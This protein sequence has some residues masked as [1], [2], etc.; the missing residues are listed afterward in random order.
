MRSQVLVSTRL[1]VLTV[2][3]AALVVAAPMASAQDDDLACGG[4]IDAVPIDGDS[5]FCDVNIGYLGLRRGGIGVYGLELNKD[6][7]T[8]YPF[9]CGLNSGSVAWGAV[10]S[11][12]VTW[13]NTTGEVIDS[14][15]GRQA[16]QAWYHEDGAWASVGWVDRW[17]SDPWQPDEERTWF[18]ATS[19]VYDMEPGVYTDRFRIVIDNKVWDEFS[20]TYEVKARP[21]SPPTAGLV[22][23]VG[24]RLSVAWEPS[25]HDGGS[26]LIGHMVFLAPYPCGE[27]EPYC[28][29]SGWRSNWE[30]WILACDFTNRPELKI[31]DIPNNTLNAVNPGQYRLAVLPLNEAFPTWKSGPSHHFDGMVY[32]W[33]SDLVDVNSTLVL[34]PPPPPPTT[35]TTTTAP[36]TVTMPTTS[37]PESPWEGPDV[38][39]EIE[40]PD[41]IVCSYRS[42][43]TLAELVF[44]ADY[45]DKLDAPVLR[46]YQAYF[47]RIPDLGGAKYWLDV[48]RNGR[49]LT[50]IAGFMAGGL[51]F[52]NTYQGTTNAQYV[53]R[54]YQN[55][56]GRNYDQAG[57]EYWLA[58]LNE[59]RLTRV[60]VVFYIT[61]NAEFIR[62]HPF[63]NDRPEPQPASRTPTGRLRGAVVTGGAVGWVNAG[64][65]VGSMTGQL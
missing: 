61:Q 43:L 34:P 64:H 23:L 55:I 54:V 1:V 37:V 65:P 39:S 11:L 40:E 6:Y 57:Y 63:I 4:W 3:L 10:C 5:I 7:M 31:C 26:P 42:A 25:M 56:L 28:P 48:R 41:R 12:Q 50:E 32:Q 47:N 20:Y 16:L 30:S 21:A 49:S 59:G 45:S 18:P 60:G 14:I 29:Y 51:E 52:A 22:Q 36:P 24:G 17:S 44:A 53:D 38:P 15:E 33:W 13:A 19:R 46:L 2:V 9:N 8:R 62:N 27:G 58:T 35:T